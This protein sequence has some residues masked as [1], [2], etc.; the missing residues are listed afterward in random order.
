M[1]AWSYPLG[2]F[3]P[4]KQPTSEHRKKWIED[5]YQMPKLLR[6]T[7]QNL[8]AESL[9]TPYRPGGWNVEQVVHHLADNDM[10]AYIRFK[11]ALTEETPIASSYREELWAKLSDYQTTPIEISLILLDALHHRFV[12]LLRTLSSEQFQ[13]TFISPTHGVMNLDIATQR[14]A[15]HGRHHMAQINSLKERMGWQ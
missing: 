8:T 6:L 9:L 11:R 5:I 12:D 10:N 4:E 13:R 3:E 15:W 14:F 1:N 2:E 7:V